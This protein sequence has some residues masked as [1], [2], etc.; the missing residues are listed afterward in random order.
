MSTAR[1]FPS[2]PVLL[3]VCA[4]CGELGFGIPWGPD[5]HSAVDR[6]FF[7]GC[8]GRERD[9]DVALPNAQF[10]SGRTEFSPQRRPEK[11][12]E[13]PNLKSGLLDLDVRLFEK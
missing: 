8:F 11:V 2:E 13:G 1:M 6:R 9:D 4:C 10:G 12:V 5:D 3:E 7:V